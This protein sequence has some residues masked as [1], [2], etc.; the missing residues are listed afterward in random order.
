MARG[1]S[2]ANR[3]GRD[4]NGVLLLDKP[5]GMTSNEALQVV[6]RL[7]N[8]R[9]AGHTGSL[10]PLATGLLPLCLGQATKISSYLLTADKHYWTRAMLGVRTD[11][12]DAEGQVLV[13]RPVPVIES[14][15]LAAVLAGYRG[16]QQQIPPMYSAVKQQGKRLYELARQGIDVD[17][18]PREI[19][20]HRLEALRL[21]GADLELDIHC[22]KGTYIRTLIEDIGEALGCGAHVTALRRY[23]V[24]PYREGDM[25]SVD[26]LR[27]LVAGDD[28]A[29]LADRLLPMD[30][31]L[32]HWPQ[33]VLDADSVFYLRE[34]Q[35]IQ[36]G[37]APTEGMVRIYG[38]Q[39]RFLGVGEIL[40]DGRVGPRR[41]LGW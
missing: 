24:G 31:A 8:A 1:K 12:G 20:I 3:G 39:D 14:D 36:V 4:I 9:K 35:A 28:A 15:R 34:G 37:G 13:T 25:V 19:V 40:D 10:D 32:A 33:V 27:E 6:K 21:A 2:R 41:L 38:P 30:S 29:G 22:S 11:T 16:V 26:H 7:L 17:R 23:G 5:A 18:E